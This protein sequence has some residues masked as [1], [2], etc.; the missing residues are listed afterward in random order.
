MKF[1]AM[2]NKDLYHCHR[3]ICSKTSNI[4]LQIGDEK[5]TKLDYSKLDCEP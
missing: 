1:T 3:V 4:V 2:C 5:P